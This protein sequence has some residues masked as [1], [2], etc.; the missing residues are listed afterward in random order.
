MNN[1][2]IML[3]ANPC[4]PGKWPLNRRERDSA[5]IQWLFI[6]FFICERKNTT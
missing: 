1:G 2:D 5:E 3:L 4:P 6:S